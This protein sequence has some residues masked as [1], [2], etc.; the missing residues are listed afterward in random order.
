MND[1]RSCSRCCKRARRYREKVAIEQSDLGTLLGSLSKW[2]YARPVLSG[3]LWWPV[4]PKK[5]Y[6]VRDKLHV[7]LKR[8]RWY[9]SLFF[10]FLSFLH[11]WSVATAIS[12]KSDNREKTTL[13]RGI[14]CRRRSPRAATLFLLFFQTNCTMFESSA[15][16]TSD[17]SSHIEI[18]RFCRTRD[19]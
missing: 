15:C 7:Q 14:S 11:G 9:V 4:V 16:L 10:F 6:Y 1:E 19:R 5:M 17:L 13:S 8:C 12:W 3:L 2:A 18:A